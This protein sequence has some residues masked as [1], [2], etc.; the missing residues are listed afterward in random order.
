MTKQDERAF[1]IGVQSSFIGVVLAIGLGFVVS[2]FQ[3]SNN[4][5]ISF[6][7]LVGGI[8]LLVFGICAYEKYRKDAIKAKKIK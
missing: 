6:I 1:I 3:S 2:S 8:I 7:N 4:S 5:I